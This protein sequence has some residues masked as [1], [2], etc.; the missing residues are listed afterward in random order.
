MQTKESGTYF[1]PIILIS[2]SVGKDTICK[3][4][5]KPFSSEIK[6]YSASVEKIF[7]SLFRNL[8]DSILYYIKQDEYNFE[9]HKMSF[10]VICKMQNSLVM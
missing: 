3:Y 1:Y 8:T 5:G 7:C 4:A 10:E 6:R 9:N 2:V